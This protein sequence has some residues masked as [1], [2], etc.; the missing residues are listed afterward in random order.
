MTT[1]GGYSLIKL[2]RD[3]LRVR[4]AQTGIYPDGWMGGVGELHALR[5]PARGTAATSR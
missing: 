2:D 4:T 3:R 1:V 5:R